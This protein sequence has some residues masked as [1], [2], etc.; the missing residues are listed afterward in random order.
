MLGWLCCLLQ[1]WPCFMLA[2]LFD[3]CSELS[4]PSWCFITS[5][6]IPFGILFLQYLF[7][8]YI[9]WL[10]QWFQNWTFVLCDNLGGCELCCDFQNWSEFITWI[11]LAFKILVAHLS[12]WGLHLIFLIKCY[13]FTNIL[14]Q[15]I[16]LL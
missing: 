4:Y 7:W 14:L 9:R 2:A 15:F 6:L 1:C 12:C 8:F 16:K 13:H 3:Y 5:W 10:F 11:C